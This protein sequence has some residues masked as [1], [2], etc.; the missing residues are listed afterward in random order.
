MPVEKC[1][2]DEYFTKVKTNS[3][4]TPT[5]PY[6]IVPNEFAY[7]EWDETNLTLL[8]DTHAAFKAYTAVKS[9]DK[10]TEVESAAWERLRDQL[11]ELDVRYHD[12]PGP[13]EIFVAGVELPSHLEAAVHLAV[14]IVCLQ[15]KIDEATSAIGGKPWGVPGKPPEGSMS[16]W[17]KALWVTGLLGGGALVIYG[18]RAF[19]NRKGASG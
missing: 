6:N 17:E 3:G 15:Q 10:W 5:H 16:I 19:Q 9:S 14:D 12:L 1:P 8:F 18:V 4:L 2:S 11:Y 13:K 7:G